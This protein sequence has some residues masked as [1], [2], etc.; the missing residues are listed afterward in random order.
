MAGAAAAD[1]VGAPDSLTPASSTLTL[2]A[3]AS[4]TISKTLHLNASPPKADVVI[5][6]D[7]TGSMGTAISQAQADAAAFVDGIK[8]QIPAARFGVVD[9]RDYAF[10]P[11]GGTGDF[12][13]MLRQALTT[14]TDS[15][16]A[17]LNAMVAGGGGDFP[18]SYNRVIYESYSD[19]ALGRDTSAPGFLV[20]LGD[21][22]PHDAG[23]ATDFPACPNKPPTDP[24]PDATVGTPDDLPTKKVA[25]GAKA[26]H[27]NVSYVQYNNVA[28][29]APCWS[30]ITTYTGG[31]QVTRSDTASLATQIVN[32]INQNAARIDE[33]DFTVSPVAPEGFN[34]G[35]WVDFTPPPKYGP[36]TAPIDVPFDETVTVPAGTAPGTYQ[37]VV[38][39][40]ADGA[41][42]ADESVTVNVTNQ[43]VSNPHLTATQSSRPP[44]VDG[45][46]F[47]AIPAS[48]IPAFAGNAA[49]TPG[50]SIPGGSIPGGSIPGGSIP[51]GSIPGGSI[52]FGSTGLGALPGGSIPG[53][54]IPGGSIPGGSIGIQRVLQS[55]LLSQIP[56]SAT[57][58]DT[59]LNATSLAG[60]PLNTLTLWDVRSD[61]AAWSNF[62]ALS[63]R[64]VSLATSLW[65]GV[66]LAAWLT[67]NATLD[68]LTPPAPYTTWPAA[69]DGSGGSA[70]G[71]AATNTTTTT[72]LD[73]VTLFGIGV[74]GQ[75]GQTDIGS[76]TVGSLPGGSIPGGSIPALQILLNSIN[77]GATRLAAVSL[78]SLSNRNDIVNC[79]GSFVCN[80]KTLG[81]AAAATAIKSNATLGM[82]LSGLP[83]G[84]PAR[85]MT[86]SE[87]IFGFLPASFYPWE[88]LDVQGLQKFAGSGKNV[89]YHFD[90]EADCASASKLSSISIA[91]P[92]GEFPVVGSSNYSVGSV[93]G[94]LGAPTTVGEPTLTKSATAWTVT[95]PVP[96]ALCGGV[97]ATRQVRWNVTTYERLPI[98]E[99]TASGSV[100]TTEGSY[101]AS[102]Q[103]PVLVTQNGEPAS[104]DQATAPVLQKD[105]L[106]VGHIGYSGD[107]D[108]GKISLG[109]LAP[110][111]KVSAYLKVPNGADFDLVLAKPDAPGVKSSPG[112]SIPGGSI[113]IENPSAFA[114]NSGR[115]LPPE[116][117][118]DVPQAIPGGSIPGGSIPGGSIPGGSIPG[119]SISANR[120]SATESALL[121]T[122]GETG[123][124]V[125]TVSGYNGSFSNDPYV[126]RI[127]VTP[128]PPLPNCPAVTG[129][130]T[131]TAGVLPSISSIPAADRPLYKTLFLVNRQRMVGL[132]GATAT[133][134][135][136]NSPTSPL[137]AA[138]ARPEVKGLIVPVDGAQAVRNAY[139]AW[140]NAPCSIPAV[141]AVV[142]KINDLADTYRAVL[143]NIKY[144]S[145]LG[146]DRVIPSWRQYDRGQISPE[147]DEAAE[148]SLT[149]NN[150][151]AGN[152]L[153]GAAAQN[154]VL[155][156]G[157]YGVRQKISWLGSD[158]PLP[159][160]SVSRFVETPGDIGAQLQQYINSGGQVDP[161][162][163][164]TTGD[165]F[166]SDSADA[167]HT[168]LLAGFQGANGG[169][170]LSGDTLYPPLNA[171]W[172]KEDLINHFFAK[173]PS[174]PDL[175]ALY[176]HYNPWL[177]QPAGPNPITSLS[178]LATTGNVPG[179]D[180]MAKR[181]LWSIGCHSG[182]NIDNT[183]FGDPDKKRDWAET[184]GKGRA[185]WIANT[186]FGYDDTESI[187][188][189]G[190][191]M[192]LFSQKL[193]RGSGSIGEQWV[194]ALNTYFLTAGNWDLLD[195]KVM[196]QATFYGPPWSHFGT[197]TPAP[198]YT[199]PSPQAKDG[200]QIASQQL[201]PVIHENPASGGRTWWDIGGLSL[202]VP[203]RSIQPLM[204][205]NVT[206][207][208]QRAHDA[209]ITTLTVN[210]LA[211][212]KPVRANPAIERAAYEPDKNFPNIY[213]PASPVSVLH[214][215]FG[216]QLNLVAGQF[217]PNPGL[218]ELGT[219]RQVQTI[220]V[221]IAYNNSTD[222]IRPLVKQAG[223]VMT[224]GSTATAFV[225]ATDESGPL[226][227]VAVLYNDGVNNFKFKQL[228]NAGGNLW[229]APLTGLAGPPEI[230]GEARD[231]SGNVGIAANKAVNF[232][233]ITDNSK[234]TIVIDSPLAGG[235]FTLGQQVRARYTCSDAGAVGSCVGTVPVGAFIDTSSVG[236]HTFSVT[237]TDLTGN[238]VEKTVEYF[239]GFA[240]L[241]FFQPVDNPPTIN[242]VNAGSTV[243]LKWKLRNAA[244]A[245]I[246]SLDVVLS[247]TSRE[248]PCATGAPLDAIEQT[249]A[250]TLI[251]LKYDTV[252]MQ[253]VYTWQTDTAWVGKCRRVFVAFSDG[254]DPRFADFKFK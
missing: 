236:T 64:Q 149:T 74:A 145:I 150:L 194:D 47:T 19:A 207:A 100:G 130:N 126:L 51:G 121:V 42:R 23:L 105:T 131:A 10:S 85:N 88:Q 252:G 147:V 159:Q 115:A 234:P 222:N 225:V 208:N 186:G 67:G 17:A 142:R 68:Q 184:Y 181:V 135:L 205:R 49:S 160:D 158:L 123:N 143:P 30:Q 3:G 60:R 232:T 37:F 218:T 151:T 204:T 5:A 230:I 20:M 250:P 58:W 122:N 79:T 209:F 56:L 129:L 215:A 91:L 119:G 109:G 136:L 193:N 157:A 202:S 78:D 233:A 62:L 146:T 50:G 229:T 168:A 183:Y 11:F 98:G 7:T 36:F 77:I 140:D 201:N 253:Y 72:A 226:N 247:V 170:G 54:S 44:G 26:N 144:V 39:A 73:D 182:L 81:Q 216:D 200:L 138:A 242:T 189:S 107:L 35:S 40:V 25:D 28:G 93:G 199:P 80:G 203:Y 173:T 239:V 34:F 27:V 245:E 29:I 52:S 70:A 117:Q 116:T 120:G 240:F 175:G 243:P 14:D 113:P 191:L 249:V 134:A 167:A 156:D 176:A 86:L 228:T 128:P 104:D 214:S 251:P 90:F 254:S 110:G 165:D 178:E 108:V 69:L 87:L 171:G 103:A 231:G 217:R 96:A 195:E 141:N 248:I 92:T 174:V 124:A 48:L 127:Q 101:V 188:M 162:T 41:T 196:L 22:F 132:Y 99:H 65:A 2:G 43:V 227:K 246:T 244:G 97:T 76:L 213:W 45:V 9:F 15:V 106:Y 197:T 61:S 38:H 46:P 133:D 95:W 185:V 235:V 59:V 8:A 224:G 153:Y 163:E 237:A 164:L 55:V 212:K 102:N 18:E 71:I 223:A 155:T 198:P 112:G 137:V 82:L 125:V 6:V 57:T 154:Y 192:W 12:P 31:Q 221:D 139:V 169:A 114:D 21:D 152:P 33:V 111:T 179:G 190:R 13:Y 220:V 66:P 166:F 148:L 219:E 180:A 1:D 172:T 4:A 211:N 206:V 210:D 32:L 118:S 16:Q 89:D 238:R 187:A 53:G 63:M 241:G 83:A 177:A 94:T 24:G 161:Q 84:D 75:L